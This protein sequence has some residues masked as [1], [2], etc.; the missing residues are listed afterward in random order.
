MLKTYLPLLI[1]NKNLLIKTRKSRSKETISNNDIPV[2]VIKENKD[3]A[4]FLIYHNLSNS[5]SSSTFSTA[6]KYADVKPAFEKYDKTDKKNC[7]SISVL[8][9]LSKVY[10]RLPLANIY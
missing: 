3:N 10:E 8:P 9:T 2:K 1:K 6:L 4:A 5:L 7:R